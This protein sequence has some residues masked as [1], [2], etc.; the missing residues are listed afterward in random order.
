MRS[1][2][3]R[4]VLTALL[5]GVAGATPAE[6]AKLNDTERTRIEEPRPPGLPSDEQM[7]AEG[8]VIGKIIFDIR[9]IFDESDRR[10][11]NDLY[12]LANDLHIRTKQSAVHAQLLF[13]EGDRYDPR[14]L[15]ETE[16][17]LRAMRPFYDARVVPVHYAGGKVDVKVITKDVWTLSPGISFGRS[18]GTNSSRFEL[19]DTNLLGWGK[20]IQIFHGSNVDRTSTAIGYDDPNLFGSH[21]TLGAGYADSSDG[22]DRSLAVGQP[23][24]SLDTLWST[25]FRARQFNR[26]VSRYNRGEIVD[27]LQRDEDYY[28]ASGGIS[29]GLVDGWVRR[30]TGGIR[31]D[32]NVF[33]PVSTALSA[34]VLPP[35]RT[36]SYPYVGFGMLQDDYR[37][38]GDLNQIGRTEDLYFGTQF[39]V[40]L[41]INSTA[42]GATRNGA[43]VNASG[44]KG[45]ELGPLSQLFLTS[46]LTSRLESG[47]VRNLIF[48]GAASYYWRWRSDRVFYVLLGGTT[49]HAL[50]PEDQL[51]IGGDSGL[52]GYP[53]RYEAGTSRALL[54][55]E[56]RF[57]TEW[58]PFRLARFGAAIFADVGRTWGRDAAGDS[59]AGMLSDIGFGLRFGNTRSGLGNVLHIDFAY[60]LSNEPGLKKF[61]VLVGTKESF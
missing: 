61:Q 15:A 60:P 14:K 59:G 54:T 52:R 50:D 5:F 6:A 51:L 16:R 28:E 21:W 11:N 22:S 35:S 4:S 3:F 1:R 41:G 26:T 46:T 32:H 9:Q 37:K 38:V 8:A 25:T 36:T 27:Q 23:F 43:I 47:G 33:R 12:R 42:L 40:E 2:T 31:Y 56:Q 20:K 18:G 45:I 7:Q 30:W 24:Y 44:Y 39:N 10:E 17:N 49:V 57:Y 13:R 48:D 19:E 55:V 29:S 58:Y 53:L 34:R